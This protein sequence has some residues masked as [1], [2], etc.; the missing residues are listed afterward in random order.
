MK[1]IMLLTIAAI[2]VLALS[3]CKSEEKASVKDNLEVITEIE[4][5]EKTEKAEE[6]PSGIQEDGK[7]T[8]IPL[9]D[10][11]KTYVLE[12][13]TE[14]WLAMSTDEKDAMVVLIGRWWEDNDGIV[15]ED[16]DDMVKVIDHQ[17]E[18]YHKNGVNENLFNTVCEIY[19]VDNSAYIT[20]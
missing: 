11:E 14:T 3:A 7:G 17:M 9:S 2:M 6:T 13:T 5:A 16:Y 20:K 12:Q 1:K 8:V 15:V 10:A 4:P 19:D 18:Q